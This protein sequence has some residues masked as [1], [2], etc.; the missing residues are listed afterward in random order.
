M[1]GARRSALV[2]LVV[3]CVSV[4]G[5]VFGCAGALAALQ[6][7]L[8][9]QLGG[10]S[11]PGGSFQ[12]FEGVAVDGAS[13]GV[14]VSESNIVQVF[15]SGGGYEATWNGSNTTAGS[16]VTRG[17]AADDG[18]GDVYVADSEHGVVDV[19]DSAGGPLSPITGVGVP[20]GLGEPIAVAVDQ[21][22]GDVYV[23]DGT[24]AGVVDIFGA[25]AVVVPDVL[26]GAAS[27]VQPTSATLNGTV[28]PDGVQ[29]SDCHFVYGP[30]EAYGQSVPCTQSAAEI[31]AGSG[32][33]AVSANVSGLTPGA[34]YHFRLFA[35][36]ANDAANESEGQDQVFGPPRVDGTSA[37]CEAKTT[38]ILEAQV[39]PDAVDTTYHFEYGTTSAYGTSAPIP[40]ADL[41]A[42]TSDQ[43]ASVEVK[44]LQSGVLYHY[45]VV[46]VNAAGTTAG[47]DDMTSGSGRRP[48]RS[49]PPRARARRTWCPTVA[50]RSPTSISSSRTKASR[51]FSSA[52]STSSTASPQASSP[53]SPTPRSPASS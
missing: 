9:G 7:P 15:G 6:Y 16:F 20:N 4:G 23:L 53:P 39:D 12:G 43:P 29:V 46:A 35:G 17:V 41:G 38:A 19:F 26:T 13:G 27:G 51:S 22:S 32:Q 2:W 24:G 42:G 48:R 30:S 50:Q 18:T 34:V 52:A 40:D 28:N 25:D 21:A 11:T 5:L 3:S 49:S 14:L 1:V 45:R 37:T 36:N 44:G 33:V 47:P 8:L 31:G 10:S